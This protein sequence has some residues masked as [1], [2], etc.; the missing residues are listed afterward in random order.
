MPRC[1]ANNVVELR[2]EQEQKRECDV[3]NTEAQ[4]VHDYE[5]RFG[6]SEY[7]LCVTATYSLCLTEM[8]LHDSEYVCVI[9]STGLRY[10]D[11]LFVRHGEKWFGMT[12]RT[13]A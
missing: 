6:H 11:V 10:G 4:G 12:E 2:L 7:C 13:C 5:Y 1:A 8:A 9:L 3:H